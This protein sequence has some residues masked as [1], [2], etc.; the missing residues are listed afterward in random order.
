[1]LPECGVEVKFWFRGELVH[2]LGSGSLS[3]ATIVVILYANNMVLP[4]TNVGKLM[5]MLTVVDL[6]ASEMAI[7][8]S[9]AKTNIMLM[10]KGAPQLPPDT[11]ICSGLMQLVEFFKYLGSIVNSQASLHE[12]VGTHRAD[13][14]G[15]FVQFFHVWGNCHISMQTKVKV[16]SSFIVPHF[17]YGSETWPFTQAQGDKLEIAYNSSL[18]R[19][20]RVGITDCHNFEHLKGMCQVPSLRW[21]LA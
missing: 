18:R 13:E 19:I 10:G 21:L 4:N 5:E 17:I 9:A 16:F 15:T 14:L 1:M 20:S 12:E 3:L 8:I 2:I 6:W 11:P 7:R